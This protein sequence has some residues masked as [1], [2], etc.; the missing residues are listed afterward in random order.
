MDNEMMPGNV[1]LSEGLGVVP[2]RCRDCALVLAPGR[3]WY[4]THCALQ[5]IGDD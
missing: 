2:E 1:P 3:S 4:C 5:H